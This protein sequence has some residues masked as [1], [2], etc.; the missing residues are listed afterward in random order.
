MCAGAVA[1]PLRR[2]SAA[3]N[4][5]ISISR[6]VAVSLRRPFAASIIKLER[7]GIVL[8]RST[9]LCTWDSAFKKAPRSTVIFIGFVPVGIAL[10][11]AVIVHKRQSL[12]CCISS[13]FL[14]TSTH[15]HHY[16]KRERERTGRD[17]AP[18]GFF[19]R[20]MPGGML[21]PPRDGSIVSRFA[22]RALVS[23]N[24]PPV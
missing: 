8:R 22:S 14:R 15:G 11:L 12:S 13:T 19:R 18:A 17:A 9:T 6:S 20:E 10:I 21:L 4:S 16:I 23:G 5:T 1:A 3:K 24:R 7:I 2:T